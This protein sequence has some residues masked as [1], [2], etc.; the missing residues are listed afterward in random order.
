[1][2]LIPTLLAVT[3]FA[4]AS[5][6]MAKQSTT[7]APTFGTGFCKPYFV[8]PTSSD[9]EVLRGMTPQIVSIATACVSRRLGLN[10]PKGY[11][12]TSLGIDS[13][14]CLTTR[15]IPTKEGGLTMVPRC[16]IK[17]VSGSPGMCQVQCTKYGLR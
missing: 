15:N 13:S 16:C 5:P 17:P 8:C 10:D 3:L 7:G 6:V 14:R 4:L 11:F 2:R 1:M 12:E 9:P